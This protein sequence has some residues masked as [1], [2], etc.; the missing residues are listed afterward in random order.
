MTTRTEQ[1]VRL[2]GEIPGAEL[3]VIPNCG[4]VPPEEC[5]TAFLTVVDNFLSR[6]D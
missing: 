1:T 2:A 6:L 5:P 3:V 4:H